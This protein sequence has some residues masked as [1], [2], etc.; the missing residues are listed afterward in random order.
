MVV[1]DDALFLGSV[2]GGCVE[3]R[4]VEEALEILQA[5]QAG[6]AGK[7]GDAGQ[8]GEA[9]QAGD[10]GPVGEPRLL[11]FGVSNEEAWE[12]GLACGGTIRVYIEAVT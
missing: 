2:S 5:S 10:A 6:D 11:S 9:S 12:V 8:I 4:V 7:A 3:G 1:R